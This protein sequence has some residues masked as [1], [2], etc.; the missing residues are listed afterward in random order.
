[1]VCCAKATIITADLTGQGL[2][3]RE[4]GQFYISIGGSLQFRFQQSCAW[5]YAGG[6]CRQEGQ[7]TCHSSLLGCR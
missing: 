5:L 3:P 7:T 2:K 6:S 1:M 4:A